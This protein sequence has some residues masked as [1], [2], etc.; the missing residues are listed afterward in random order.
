MHIS[1][2]TLGSLNKATEDFLTGVAFCI[3]EKAVDRNQGLYFLQ[4]LSI[5]I[6]R[7][8]AASVF[9]SMA[10]AAEE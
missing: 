4:Q 1:F 6:Q 7:G 2:E 10:D 5:A 9:A 3:K 8:N